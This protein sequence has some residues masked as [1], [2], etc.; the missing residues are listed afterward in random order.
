M[1][2]FLD[3]P[4]KDCRGLRL[5]R[6]P[7]FLRVVRTRNTKRWDACDQLEDEPRPDEEIFVYVRASKP[8]RAFIR[9]G[10]LVMI[11]SYQFW[12]MQPDDATARDREAWRAW[13]FKSARESPEA[14]DPDEEDF[15][16]ACPNT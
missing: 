16:D 10:G 5:G 15:R 12:P 4:A 8:T 1:I 9:P 11:C 6:T 13:C 2:T 3:G 14:D 7:Y